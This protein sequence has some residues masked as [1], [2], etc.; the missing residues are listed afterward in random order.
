M[1]GAKRLLF[2]L[3]VLAAA[4][5]FLRELYQV[6]VLMYHRIDE[7]PPGV[8]EGL[9]VS[10]ET[11]ERQME[12]LKVHGYRVLPL[13]EH[14]RLVKAGKKPPLKSVVI[15]FDDGT[16]DNMNHAFPVLK[17]MG[18][19]ATVFMITEN[20]GREGWLS[21]EDLRLM[22]ASGVS[23]GSHTVTHA[24][25]PNVDDAS[26]AH[27]IE[28]SKARLEE[29]LDGPVTLFSYPGGGY[30]HRVRERVERAGYLAAVTTNYGRR[31][32][33]WGL[34]RVKIKESGG[35]LFNF[36]AKT[37]GFYHLGK[38]RMAVE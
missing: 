2:I 21:E 37:S 25:L 7:A 36:W 4:A 30:T 27:E 14:A 38:K 8:P 5:L 22:H 16:I 33:A 15:T 26:A 29:V 34:H 19:P 10:P 6:P 3:V 9:C 28:A 32:N 35:S 1:R 20:I 17:K 18:F 11:F 24:F 31:Q 12:F 23:I 13:E